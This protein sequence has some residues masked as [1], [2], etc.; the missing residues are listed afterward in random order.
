MTFRKTALLLL[1]ALLMTLLSVA[2]FIYNK[3]L[4]SNDNQITSYVLYAQDQ[5]GDTIALL[6]TIQLSLNISCPVPL[7]DNIPENQIVMQARQNPAPTDFPITV[8]E[9]VYPKDTHLY[10]NG[11][12]LVKP[13]YRSEHIAVLGDSGCKSPNQTCTLDSDN[14]FFN[15]L[16]NISA[17]AKPEVVLHMGDYN[18]SG[19]PGSIHL[20]GEESKVQVYD[21]GDNTTQGMCKIAGP[22]YGQNSQG[23][24]F[25]DSWKH[26]QQDFFNPAQPLLS[27]APW[28]FARGNH[29]LCSRA[30]PGWFYL[31]D[32]NSPLL[33]K[34]QKQL[35]CPAAN[36]SS[37]MIFSQPYALNL[38]KANILVLDSTNAC[39]SGLLNLEQYQ[40]QFL[41]G[42][43]MLQT[44]PTGFNILQ[45]H[46]PMFAIDKLANVGNC[47]NTQKGAYC[48]MSQT[49]QQANRL[50]GLTDEVQLLISGHM[51][52]FQSTH[53]EAST[54]PDQL[55]VGTSGVS[56]A[57]NFPA[58]P[59]KVKIEKNNAYVNGISQYAY[60]KLEMHAGTAADKMDK[61]TDKVAWHATLINR[62]AEPLLVC[63][64]GQQQLC[65]APNATE[66]GLGM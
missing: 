55:V 33:G 21:A 13:S 54:F 62:H 30:G 50:T 19:T 59:S 11:K 10:L 63:Q 25:K 14:W 46:R 2:L 44:L 22:Y 9:A 45:T 48:P 49:L 3:P 17:K 27:S 29:E 4:T 52:R 20:L 47:G 1:V 53:F 6:R 51:H 16:A 23:S 34:Y 60:L 18:Y 7:I 36:N 37:P 15:T 35:S 65:K 8:C 43:Q 40:N 28:V 61:Q 32:S 24:E 5:N 12:A 38:G 42:K 56:L 41:L 57:G 58:K 31:L 39:D 64:P 26:W 66:A